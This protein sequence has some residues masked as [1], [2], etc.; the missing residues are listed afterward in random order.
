MWP[1]FNWKGSQWSAYIA[2]LQWG[3]G[4][5][6]G[7]GGNR[8]PKRHKSDP[9]VGKMPRR[10]EWQPI[11]VFLPGKFQGQRSLA[12]YI[13]RGRKESDMTEGLSMPSE[14]QKWTASVV[15]NQKGGGGG[16]RWQ[17]RETKL[18]DGLGFLSFF[19]F[20][21]REEFW[22]RQSVFRYIQG[23]HLL[24]PGRSKLPLFLDSKNLH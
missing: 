10:R 20:K 13:P 22:R 5:P 16:G 11:P 4:F 7:A 9:W 23:T 1:P 3:M 18:W 24:W 15:G 19:L 2:Y 14:G 12:G 6:G 21:L 8:R 17:Q